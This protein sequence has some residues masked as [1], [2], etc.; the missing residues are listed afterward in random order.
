M[1]GGNVPESGRRARIC[2]TPA[3]A[4]PY[5]LVR[6]CRPI[7]RGRRTKVSRRPVQSSYWKE[8]SRCVE[9]VIG[10]QRDFPPGRWQFLHEHLPAYILRSLGLGTVRVGD[11]IG[12]D[13]P[14]I[15]KL[16]AGESV[17]TRTDR[18][19]VEGVSVQGEVRMAGQDE[20]PFRALRRVKG[21]ASPST[22]KSTDKSRKIP[23]FQLFG[24][25][26]CRS[27]RTRS[28]CRL[29]TRHSGKTA[30]R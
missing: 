10:V 24:W 5:N 16:P 22:V 18:K 26:R 8:S 4:H 11:E 28:H 19:L 25:R 17:P 14:G 13:L 30:T 12:D 15:R 3:P 29:R 2:E 6:N 9:E 20:S 23:S 27:Y 7:V 1:N 21:C